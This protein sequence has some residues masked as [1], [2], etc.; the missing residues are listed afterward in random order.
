MPRKS[1]PARRQPRRVS[2]RPNHKKKGGHRR[3]ARKVAPRWGAYARRT[4]TILLSEGTEDTSEAKGCQFLHASVGSPPFVTSNLSIVPEHSFLEMTTYNSVTTQIPQELKMKG[5]AIFSKYLNLRGEIDFTPTTSE[6]ANDVRF[7]VICGYLPMVNQMD[8][9][10]NGGSFQKMVE[11]ICDEFYTT[12][13]LFGGLNQKSSI[14]IISD[15]TY[16]RTPK[17]T[18]SNSTDIKYYRRNIQISATFP[19]VKGKHYYIPADGESN[20]DA[21]SPLNAVMN[22]QNLGRP[23]LVPFLFVQNVDGVGDPSK[24]VGQQPPKISFRWSHY[25]ND[26]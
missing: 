14:Q 5:N 13:K 3:V 10:I 9:V 7:R 19:R 8:A 6:D 12:E 25:L 20:Y 26:A 22:A 18:Q 15:R 24:P 1:R 23:L 4:E 2:R 17:S 21:T 16:S 11:N